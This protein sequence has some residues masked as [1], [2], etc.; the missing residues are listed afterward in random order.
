[1]IFKYL[2]L[3]LFIISLAIGLL[4]VYLSEE[5]KKVIF[6]HPTPDNI[7]Q[8]QYQDGS[9]QCFTYDLEKTQ[10]PMDEKKYKEIK[11]QK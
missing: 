6:I 7:D 1:M 5:Y 2:N 3:K 11:I 9:D 10:C 8:Y 4:Y